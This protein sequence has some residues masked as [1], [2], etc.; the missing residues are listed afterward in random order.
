MSRHVERYTPYAR[1]GLIFLSA[2]LVA[3]E[4]LPAPF[5]EIITSLA[6]DPAVV[7]DVAALISA[8]VALVWYHYSQA[9]QA[10]EERIRGRDE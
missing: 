4:R 7:A 6:V 5:E 3:T 8:L 1:Y 2:W 9:K 10:L